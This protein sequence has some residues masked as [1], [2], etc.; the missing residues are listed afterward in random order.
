MNLWNKIVIGTKFLFGGFES[1]T[2]Y[3]LK[4]LNQFLSNDRVIEKIQRLRSFTSSALKFLRKYEKYCPA[5]WAGD[6]ARLLGVVQL[7]VDS[8]QDSKFTKDEI[9]SAIEAV[10]KAIEDWNK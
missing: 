7:L 2:D 10:K 9:Y 6:F 3:L 1:V 5:I 4:L 8:L